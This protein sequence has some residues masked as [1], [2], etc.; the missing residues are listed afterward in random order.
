MVSLIAIALERSLPRPYPP[1]VLAALETAYCT[2]FRN[3]MEFVHNGRPPRP[4]PK[5]TKVKRPKRQDIWLNDFTPKPV[6]ITWTKKELARFRAA[7]QLGAHPSRGRAKR[8]HAKRFWGGPQDH[9]MLLER[10]RQVFQ[11]VPQAKKT[12]PRTA[13]LLDFLR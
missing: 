3:F 8:R 2:H 10:M 4:K 13:R 1:H 6:V 12:F 9:R 5:A 7:D 11:A